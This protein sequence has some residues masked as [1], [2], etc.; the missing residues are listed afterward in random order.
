MGYL[1]HKHDVAFVATRH[2]T[3]QTQEN[4][5]QSASQAKQL[6]PKPT[7]TSEY[8]HL[9]SREMIMA[10]EE[11]FPRQA[12][13]CKDFPQFNIRGPIQT[14]YVFWY[15]YRSPGAFQGMSDHHRRLMELLTSWIDGNYGKTYDVVVRQQK[16]SVVS[17]ETMPSLVW[18]G[19]VLVWE[20]KRE[21]KAAIAQSW[22]RQIPYHAFVGR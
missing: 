3:P 4:E 17:Q 19:D 11:F 1:A 16:E 13:F 9:E 5:V 8:I 18:P 6:L 15:C 2:Y 14:P 21:S 10:A 22:P 7:P 12:T 20:D